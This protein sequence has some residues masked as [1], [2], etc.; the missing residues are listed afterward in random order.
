MNTTI[1]DGARFGT[2]SI[3][4]VIE[5]TGSNRPSADEKVECIEA[6]IQLGDEGWTIAAHLSTTIGKLARR[7]ADAINAPFIDLDGSD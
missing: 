6:V 5:V 1:I 4:G 3:Q 2:V 7:A